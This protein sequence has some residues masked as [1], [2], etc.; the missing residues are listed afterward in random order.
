LS[1]QGIT[2]L[3]SFAL[4]DL[5]RV[6]F[7]VREVKNLRFAHARDDAAGREIRELV[8]RAGL[9]GRGDSVSGRDELAADRAGD[10]GLVRARDVE[11]VGRGRGWVNWA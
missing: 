3:A 9:H 10:G 2:L 1:S 8:H 11:G 7:A 5:L 4:N 6:G